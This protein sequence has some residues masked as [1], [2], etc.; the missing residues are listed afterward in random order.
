M[1]WLFV[2]QEIIRAKTA[3]GAYRQEAL[4]KVDATPEQFAVSLR[5]TTNPE[6]VSSIYELFLI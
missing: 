5:G 2:L 1:P 6:T 3:A 4:G